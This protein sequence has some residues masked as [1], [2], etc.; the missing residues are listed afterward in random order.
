MPGC[1]AGT[2]VK[3]SDNMDWLCSRPQPRVDLETIP[4]IG[5][6]SG[7]TPGFRL[8]KEVRRRDVG[9]QSYGRGTPKLPSAHTDRH[10]LPEKTRLEQSVEAATSHGNVLLTSSDKH[11]GFLPTADA[12][13]FLRREYP[14]SRFGAYPS[15]YFPR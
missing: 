8:D 12:V 6:V 1:R 11:R 7:E 3:R 9:A 13:L 5:D 14:D 10:G 2:Q 4:F 15:R